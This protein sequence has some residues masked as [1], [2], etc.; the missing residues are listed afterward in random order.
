M[1]AAMPCLYFTSLPTKG[2]LLG[3]FQCVA[4]DKACRQ[5]LALQQHI[6]PYALLP[7]HCSLPTYS[8]ILYLLPHAP[9][10]TLPA[11]PTLCLSVPPTLILS[12]FS[13]CALGCVMGK[14]CVV[15]TILPA[16]RHPPLRATF[17]IFLPYLTCLDG[18]RWDMPT[19]D[20]AG[21]ACQRHLCMLCH[22]YALPACVCYLRTRA[23][24]ALG[25]V[26]LR[27]RPV[28]DV[29]FGNAAVLH[30][31]CWAHIYVSSLRLVLRVC[32]RMDVV[33]TR[34]PALQTTPP[35]LFP[36]K[37]SRL[38]KRTAYVLV[39]CV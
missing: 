13:S 33:T 30:R 36:D 23:L 16:W 2:S 32:L 6:L 1:P 28:R 26:H 25:F 5:A 7:G 11:L 4:R 20:N 19:S 18:L 38:I 15:G 12:L 3:M 21:C 22:T 14:M 10:P 27:W 35:T 17:D 31:F 24:A 29:T 8:A 34:P 9:C 39:C 37:H